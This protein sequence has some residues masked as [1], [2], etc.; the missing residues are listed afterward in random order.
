MTM[1]MSFLRRS[2]LLAMI[3]AAF[4]AA[5]PAHAVVPPVNATLEPS[6]IALGESAQLTIT[7]SGNT[8]DQ[9]KLP[10]VEG[11]ELRIVG[12][13][14]RIQFINGRT[15]TSLSFIVRVTPQTAGIF[16]IPDVAPNGEPLVLRVTPAGGAPGPGAPGM[17]SSANGT[18]MAA[19]GAAFVRLILPKRDIY[20]GESVPV[21]IE[22]GLRDGF[23]KPNALPTLAGGDF[24]LNNLSHQPEQTPRVVDGKPYMVLTWH[25]VVAAVKPGKFSLTVEAPLTVRIRTRSQRDSMIEDML[26]DP[27]MQ[28]IFGASITK[29]I[30]AT[31]MPSD[32][33]VL[34]LPVEGRPPY[35]SGAVGSFKIAADISST[36]AA[37]GD[38]LT[39][40]MHVTGTG[41]FDRVDS[42]MLEHLDQ[43]KTYPPKSSFKASDALGLKGEKIFEQPLI[44]SKP[45]TQNLPGLAFS[46]FDPSAHRYETVRSEPLNVTISPSQADASLN[47]PQNAPPNAPTLP[48]GTASSDGLAATASS[49]GG[50]RPD[51]AVTEAGTDTLVPPYLQPRFLTIPSLLALSFAGGWWGLRRRATDSSSARGRRRGASKHSNRVLEGLAT[52]A[53]AGDAASFFTL[54]RAALERA[55]PTELE[56]ERLEARRLETRP[57]TE[58]EAGRGDENDDIRRFLAL[59]DEVNYAGLRPTPAEFERWIQFIRDAFQRGAFQRDTLQREDVR[60]RGELP[61]GRSS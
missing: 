16:N 33:T 36:S 58:S 3:T 50:L 39:L 40:R 24:T 42:A 22:I 5:A 59:S 10:H 12:Q 2:G 18:R 30:T 27:F 4:M 43:W 29:D 37:A 32:L 6:Q 56:A 54:A 8:T 52:A 15:L 51:H 34:E 44:A 23:A 28:N 1:R 9:P 49:N 47:A 20:V 48:T 13:S 46:Y 38:P 57:G 55:A 19:D 61:G 7:S 53:R 11:L 45:G 31:S 60:Q 21:E 25:S 14:Q 17:S 26:G 41:N 35:F